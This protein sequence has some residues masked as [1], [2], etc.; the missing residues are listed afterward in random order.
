MRNLTLFSFILFGVVSCNTEADKGKLL[1][2]V[3]EEELYSSEL[4]FLF[5]SEVMSKEDSAEVSENYINDWVSKQILSQEALANEKIDQEEINRKTTSFKNDLLV[6]E[7]EQSLVSERL[8]TAVTDAE[9]TSYYKMHQDDFQLNDYL[10]KV[11]Y[12]KIAV[13]A[14]DIDKVSSWYKLRKATDGAALDVYA[15]IYAKNYYYDEENWIYFDDLLK[16]IPL[17]DINKD[18]FI[19]KQ[20]KTRFEDGGYYY[21]LNVLDYKL[22]NTVSPLNFEKD[23]IKERIINVRVKELREEIK[24]EIIS[25]ANEK[26]AVKIY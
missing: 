18:R 6:M 24:N 25:K 5:S 9:I 14:P 2:K 4:G 7:L 22:K 23:N 3:Y 11:L 19:M 16:E 20:S 26:N 8:D 12:I 21:F 1:A 17:H 15:K 10:V 13:D